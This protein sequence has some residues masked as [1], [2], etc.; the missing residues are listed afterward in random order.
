MA[1]CA[2]A[3]DYRKLNSV[4]VGH[5]H[6]LPRVDDIFD[7]LGNAQYFSTL[8]LK[9]AY[10]QISV[11]EKDQRG[12]FEFNRMPL[13]LVNAPTTF[14]RAMDLVLSGLCYV[15]CSCYI[16]DAIVF[17]R[18]FKEHC[19]RL[20][21]TVLE[22]LCLHGLRVKPEKCTIAARQVSFSGHG[23]SDSGVSCQIQRKLKLST[24]FL[25]HAI[26]EVF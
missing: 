4:T 11:D 16:D 9:S 15:I 18:D 2:F 8:D 12:L 13:G 21:T 6:P 17:G 23:V 25:A 19:T 22:R 10:W 3:T 20:K 5:A 14:Q 7:S 26:F 24:T 1:K